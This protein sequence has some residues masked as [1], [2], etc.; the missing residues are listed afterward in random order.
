MTFLFQSCIDNLVLIL[1]AVMIGHS[2]E[3]IFDF[4]NHISFFYFEV[5]CLLVQVEVF[6]CFHVETAY[7][8]DLINI[9]S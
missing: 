2:N 9:V 6:L 1:K 3:I 7:V 8:V 5:F 4:K